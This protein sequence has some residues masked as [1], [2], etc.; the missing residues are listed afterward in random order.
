MKKIAFSLI[1]LT[2]L[3]FSTQAATSKLSLKSARIV[4][5]EQCQAR[6]KTEET[7]VIAQLPVE[8]CSKMSIG[9][10]LT[11][12]EMDVVPTVAAPEVEFSGDLHLVKAQSKKLGMLKA[13][14]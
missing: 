4:S 14:Q 13:S 2:V 10:E 6:L 3:S 9:D 12:L 1:V 5:I 7:N 8:L 11:E